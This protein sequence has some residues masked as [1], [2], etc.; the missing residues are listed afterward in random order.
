MVARVVLGPVSPTFFKDDILLP[1]LRKHFLLRY[2]AFLSADVME[3]GTPFPVWSA[4]TGV[5][6]VGGMSSCSVCI[7]GRS[8]TPEAGFLKTQTHTEHL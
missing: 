8:S 7:T 3:Y 4:Q 2:L 1:A 6:I 5:G